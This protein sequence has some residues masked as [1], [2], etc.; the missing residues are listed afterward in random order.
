MVKPDRVPTPG[1]GVNRVRSAPHPDESCPCARPRAARARRA[2]RPRR[3]AVPPRS[4]SG[5]CAASS[6]GRG[7]GSPGRAPSGRSGLPRR[8]SGSSV[9]SSSAQ[10]RPA[11]S[12]PAS[13]RTRALVVEDRRRDLLDGEHPLVRPPLHAGGRPRARAAPG[14]GTRRAASS[15]STACSSH[16]DRRVARG[17]ELRVDGQLP[18]GEVAE[19]RAL[20]VGEHEVVERGGHG[21]G[22]RRVRVRSKPVGLVT[23]RGRAARRSSSRCG[24]RG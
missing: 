2:S 17:D 22:P 16:A 19:E 6:S 12:S 21:G 3:R 9:T 13:F 14:R 8:S 20:V 1:P 10:S 24:S 5:R 18:P 4:P 11:T 23:A 15:F 7:R